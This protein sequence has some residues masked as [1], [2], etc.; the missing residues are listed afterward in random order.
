LTT[1]QLFAG[2]M[3]RYAT[4]YDPFRDR[5]CELETVLDTLAAQTRAWREDR[6]G[7]TLRGMRHWKRPRMR[8]FFGQHGPL[9][10][11]DRPQPDRPTLAWGSAHSADARVEDGFLRSRGLGAALVPPVSLVLDRTG[12]YYDPSRPSDLERWIERRAVLTSQEEA[13]ARRLI[14]R[15]REAGLSKYNLK[16]AACPS[17]PQGAVLVVGQVEDD[18]SLRLGGRRIT[19]NLALLRE[20]RAARPDAHLVYKPHPDVE[21][22][23]RP[24]AVPEATVTE[25]ADRVLREAD[26]A[27]V[28]ASAPEVWTMTSLMGFEA[29]MRGCRV[30]TLGA[31]FY[32]GWGLTE[33]HGPVP[34]RRRA[35]PSIAGLV[36]AALI[37]Y[38]RYLDPVTAQPCPVEVIVDRLI[39]DTLPAPGPANRALSRLQGLL[40]TAHPFWR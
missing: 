32:A 28:L 34:A 14:A 31:P 13:R 25:L 10:F 23:L 33:D 36:H 3:L 8:A 21:A 2:A 29:L 6:R 22:G 37:D 26:P 1:V 40:A 16:G 9:R 24:G 4:W 11:S 12:L 30:V 15:I 5:L 38:P 19:T 7:W 17:L 27:A 20:A 39:E 18:A 35:R